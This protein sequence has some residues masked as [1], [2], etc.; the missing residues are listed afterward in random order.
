MKVTVGL[1]DYGV[2][3]LASV[4]QALLELGLRCRVSAEPSTLNECHVLLLPGVGAF[5]PAMAALRARALDEYLIEQQQHGRPVFG[6]CLGMQLLA[7][8]SSEGGPQEGLAL[9][10][11]TVEAL[12]PN[13][14]HIG[15]NTL[16]VVTDDPLFVPSQGESFYFNHA[17]AFTSSNSSAVATAQAQRSFP[18]IVRRNNVVGVQFH[19]EKSQDAGRRLLSTV[20]GGLARG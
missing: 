10:D 19:P 3:N 16:E 2:G 8:S 5:K 1:V 13:A 9:I 7:H 12:G 15:W 6:I 18:A 11:G 17:F 14:W 20:I 4:R